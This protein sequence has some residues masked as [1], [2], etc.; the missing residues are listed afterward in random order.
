MR[1]LI[2][3]GGM[4]LRMTP[5]TKRIPKSLLEVNR[6]PIL[7]R[8]I[9]ALEENNVHDLVIITGHLE[10]Q[11]KKFMEYNYPRIT[12]KFLFSPFYKNP[13][14]R[15]IYPMWLARNILKDEDIIYIHGD[16][17]F[18]PI[19]AKK[20]INFPYS[21]ALLKKDFVPQKD[22]KAKIEKGL[23]KKIGVDVFDQGA[24][25]CLPFCKI[26]RKDF[27]L[28][29]KKIDDFVKVKNLDCYAEDALNEVLDKIRFY[30]VYYHQELGMEIDDFGD[31]KKAEEYYGKGGK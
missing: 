12:P 10:D 21:G 18:D 17:V 11:I 24:S 1:A 8:I 13:K 3:A 6:E 20:I 15:Y 26:L 25:F 9:D 4:G 2:I 5:L 22:F 28:W 14:I 16:V 19:L 27:A 29:M 31:L 7:K 30:P 23:I